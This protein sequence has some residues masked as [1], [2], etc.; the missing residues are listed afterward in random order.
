MPIA[1]T[2]AFKK[3]YASL[4]KKAKMQME[5]RIDLFLQDEFSTLLNNHKLHG[6]Y[7]EYRSINITSDIRLVYKQLGKGDFI[8][9]AIGTH[10]QLYE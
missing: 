6:K 10:S 8:F 9:F 7:A 4:P 3:A 1:H 2:S 5:K